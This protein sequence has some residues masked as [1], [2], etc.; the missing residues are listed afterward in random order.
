MQLNKRN[1]CPLCRSDAIS[2]FKKGT[3]DPQTLS[4]DHFKI[5]DSSYGSLWTFS[6][7]RHCGFVFSNPYAP[8][9]EIASFYAQLEDR[10]YSAEADGRSKNF[11][12][13]LKRLQRLQQHT[14]KATASNT[15]HTPHTPRL[16]D[17][18][19]ASGIF[20][21][22]AKQ[23]GYQVEGIEP[24][25]FLVR[26]A[27]KKYGLTLFKGTLEDYKPTG[28]FSVITL[29]D[30]I[31]HLV[32]PDDFMTTLDP[33]MEE[34]GLLVVVTP[35]IGSLAARLMGSRWWHYRVAHVNFFN[36]QSLS[37]LLQKHNY[38]IIL[39]KKYVW[40]FSLY[41][42]LTRIFPFLMHKRTL[43]KTLKRLHLKLP[44]FDSWE[45]YARKRKTT[46]KRT[47]KTTGT[48]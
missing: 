15:T 29:L 22:L 46:R 44:L 36:R 11:N 13:I 35:D 34:N 2:L 30:I 43:Q 28:K 27:E 8:E 42:L 16:L 20:L 47:G 17:I 41:Y 45:I 10:E 39:T 9:Q 31:E 5:T 3:F 40:H 14:A 23:Y 21:D 33:L 19:A 24:S 6:T 18:G 48:G 38:E 4:T 1:Q 12:T 25:E 32:E 7:C 37:Y 26:E